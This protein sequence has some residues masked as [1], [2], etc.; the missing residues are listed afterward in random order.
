MPN[1][2]TSRC[3]L[4]LYGAAFCL[5]WIGIFMNRIN[6]TPAPTVVFFR[7]L[8]AVGALLIIAQDRTPPQTLR[9]GLT[10]LGLGCLQAATYLF[11]LSAFRTTSVANAAFLH[12]L[13]PVFVLLLAPVTLGERVDGRLLGAL[14]PALVGTALLTGSYRLTGGVQLKPGD[15]LATCSAVTYAGYTLLGRATGSQQQ[16]GAPRMALW[17]HVMALPLIAGFNALTDWGGFAVAAEDWPYIVLLAFI[18]T[19]LAFM[20]FFKGLQMLPASQSTLIM[21]LTPVT[22]ALLAWLILDEPLTLFQ[23]LGAALIVGAAW[24]ARG[25]HTTPTPHADG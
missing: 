24:L 3:A 5:G 2:N 9:E 13:A 10:F 19:A 7:V 18:S 25:S 1:S 8:L 22:S 14:F 20:L 15:G 4:I 11:Y 21:L 12:Y 6:G 16:V 17:V 23:I